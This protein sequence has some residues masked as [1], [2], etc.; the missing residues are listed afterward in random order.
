MGWWGANT[1]Q[2]PWKEVVGCCHHKQPPPPLLTTPHKNKQTA[3]T[4]KTEELGFAS[5]YADWWS[6]AV[7]LGMVAALRVV[8]VLATRFWTWEKR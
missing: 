7:L 2:H 4:T 3:T 6:L 5:P 1:A 8:L